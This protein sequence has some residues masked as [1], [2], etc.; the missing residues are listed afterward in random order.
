MRERAGR[1]GAALAWL[2]EAA[3]FEQER[4]DLHA[5]QRHLAAA[6]GIAPGD[7]V[8]FGCCCMSGNI[9]VQDSRHRD[10]FGICVIDANRSSATW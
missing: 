8:F 6:I 5:A 7:E 9:G 3:R 1:E 10:R 2:E 4:G